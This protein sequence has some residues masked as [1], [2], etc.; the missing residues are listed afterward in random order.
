[1]WLRRGAWWAPWEAASSW[2]TIPIFLSGTED[3]ALIRSMA[4]LHHWLGHIRTGRDIDRARD[5]FA[6]LVLGLSITA[7]SVDGGTGLHNAP[8]PGGENPEGSALPL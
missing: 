8:V 3:S 4:D 2:S 6:A 1:L 5:K 7:H